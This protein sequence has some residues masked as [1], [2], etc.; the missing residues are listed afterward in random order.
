METYATIYNYGKYLTYVLYGVIILGLW[1]SAS[2]YLSAVE[3]F[4]Q[5]FVGLVLVYVNNPFTKHR[6]TSIDKDIA[7]S[8]GVFLLTSTTISA[9]LRRLR[10]PLQDTNTNINV[11]NH[12]DDD[13]EPDCGC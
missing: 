3:Y 2:Q 13:T 8:A 11:N 7:F 12:K 4:F 1:G 10:N 6:Y 9:F 5:I